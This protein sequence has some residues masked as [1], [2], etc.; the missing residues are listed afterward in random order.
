MGKKS[1]KV[2]KRECCVSSSR[3]ARCPIRLLKEGKL[4]AGY[5]VHKRRLV[6][7]GPSGKPL[8]TKVKKA[9]VAAALR[10]SGKG[11]AKKRAAA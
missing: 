5:G 6:A 4:P 8:N 11:K 7:V 9:D 1:V 2:P 10:K 3:C